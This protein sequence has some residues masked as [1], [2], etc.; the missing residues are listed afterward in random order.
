MK[1]KKPYVLIGLLFIAFA[2]VIPGGEALSSQGSIRSWLEFMLIL[3]AFLLSLFWVKKSY[4]KIIFSDT[5]IIPIILF[6]FWSISTVIWSAFRILSLAKSIEL[7][8]V[9]F[10]TLVI[11]QD[12]F[13]NRANTSKVLFK[14]L[15]L[16][17]AFLFLFNV[18]AFGTPFNFVQSGAYGSVPRIRFTLGFAHPLETADLLALCAIT[19]ISAS[20]SLKNILVLI[21]LFFCIYLADARASQL[22]V[23]FSVLV[24]LYFKIEKK[25]YKLL[26][27]CSGFLIV[28]L[29]VAYIFLSFDVQKL[30]YSNIAGVDTLGGRVVLWYTA[31]EAFTANSFITIFGVGYYSSRVLLLDIAHYGGHA[32][33]AYIDLMLTT[34]LV[35]VFILFFVLVRTVKMIKHDMLIKYGF[36]SGILIYTLLISIFDP[37]LLR[38]NPVMVV[39]FISFIEIRSLKVGKE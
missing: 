14:F 27:V 26:I 31:M 1:V 25:A 6:C 35:G 20:R 15:I 33:N 28:L 32:H 19:G 11:V 24:I 17:L 13:L 38:P 2:P 29:S 34:G 3:M 18:L 7:F 21:F 37:Q 16:Y 36:F 10:V 12:L 5:Y 4:L 23:L 9:F 8:M 30:L 39:L 22:F